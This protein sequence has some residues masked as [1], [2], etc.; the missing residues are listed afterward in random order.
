MK[1]VPCSSAD[2]APLVQNHFEINHHASAKRAA[3]ALAM[4][5]VTTQH[6]LKKLKWHPCKIH[7]VQKLCNE[8]KENRC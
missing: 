2:N 6:T 3:V 7:I 8:D 4:N 5:K 1:N